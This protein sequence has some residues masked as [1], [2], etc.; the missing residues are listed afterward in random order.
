MQRERDRAALGFAGRGEGFS[1]GEQN[2]DGTERK[3]GAEEM[4]AETKPRHTSPKAQQR[5]PGEDLPNRPASFRYVLD[6]HV[7]FE[8]E[9]K[10]LEVIPL[11]F[12]E[13]GRWSLQ[14]S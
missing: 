10:A 6:L 5:Q 12:R 13:A 8:Q 7:R 14:S 4:P 3:G 11:R 2:R 9:D 1:K